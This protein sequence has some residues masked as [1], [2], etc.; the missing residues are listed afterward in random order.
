MA[1]V[2][3]YLFD[4]AGNQLASTPAVNGVYSF[5]NLPPGTYQ[6]R[7]SLPPGRTVTPQD[8]GPDTIDNDF[9]ASGV[10]ALYTLTPG[11]VLDL[12][13]GWL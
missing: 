1:S 2:T 5:N 10:S 11:A 6:V 7:V 8:A 4:G 13:I 3:V 9:N 12:D